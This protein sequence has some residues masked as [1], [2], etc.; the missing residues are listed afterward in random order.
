M[1]AVIQIKRSTGAGVPGSGSSALAQGELAYS[2][3]LSSGSEVGA[4]KLYIGMPADPATGATATAIVIGG[5][6]YTN[7]LSGTAGNAAASKAVILDANNAVSGLGAVGATTFTGTTVNGGNVRIA[8]N[9]VSSTD[10]DGALNLNPNGSGLI[11]IYG[12][13]ATNSW[14]LPR[15]RGTATYVLTTNADGTTSWAQPVSVL[16]FDNAAG[17]TSTVNLLNQKLSFNGGTGISTSVS[18]QE[19]TI[20]IDTGEGG[21][22]TT[23]G[24]QTL[25][26]KTMDGSLNTFLNIGNA[27]LSNSSATI[28]GLVVELGGSISL[29]STNVAEGTNLYF[30]DARARAAVSATTSGDGFGNLT[31]DSASGT[32]T[33]AKVTAANVRGTLAAAN[34]A[35]YGS[36]GYDS[37][38]GTFTFTA[39]TDANIRDRMSAATSG[40]GYGDLTYNAAGGTFTFAKVTDANIRERFAATN[41]A[42]FGSVAYDSASGTFTFTAVTA[43]NIRDQISA[44]TN[45]DATGFGNLEYNT[46]TGAITMTKVSVA[47]VRSTLGAATTGGGF[48][49]LTYDNASG[50]FT[51]ATVTAG[52]VRGTLST[53]NTGVGYGAV[54]Y[55]SSTGEISFAKV[56]DAEIRGT[57]SGG[58]GVSYNTTSGAISIGQSVATTDNVTFNKVT[59]GTSTFASTD[60]VSKA[61]VDSVAQG[62]D[63]KGSVVAATTASITL[64]GL[65]TIDGV[66]ITANMRVLVKN[67]SNATENGIWVASASAWTRADDMSTGDEFP[68][69]FTFVEQGTTYADTG[70]VQTAD[71]VTVGTTPITWVQF[72]SAGQF[73][74]GDGLQ[75]NGLVFSVNPNLAGNGL[76]YNAGVMSV[77]V[78]TAT[79]VISGDSIDIAAGG[80]T[81]AMLQNSGITF[82][83]TSGSTS[84]SLGSA[85]SIVGSGAV[86]TAGA[87][88]SITISVANATT[89]ST[90]LASFSATNFAVTDGAVSIKAGGVNLTTDVT[91]TL[92]AVNGGTGL[93]SYAVGDLVFANTTQTLS[94]LAATGTGF[95]L[96]SAGA[97]T[98]PTYGKIGLTTHVDG[99][100]A[101]ANGGTGRSTLAA[102]QLLVGDGTNA[103]AQSANLKFEAAANVGGY[104]NTANVLT[105][106]GA[107]IA[108]SG[109]DTVITANG[110][111]GNIVLVPNG[112]GFVDIGGPNSGSSSL[113]S[114][115]G[116][117]LNITGG[118][119]LNLTANTTLTLATTSSDIVM[120]LAAST[121]TKVSISG[122]TAAQYATGIEDNDL[123]NALW[124]KNYATLDGGTY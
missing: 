55:N 106:G 96:I 4:G 52:D 75:L 32:F 114:S 47:N 107:S 87:G 108:T 41:T 122:P 31:Y 76:A 85:L 80:V 101:V 115:N 45:V 48:G 53:T 60:A 29:T 56:T 17:S 58:T 113:G 44:G 25:T 21:L 26:N 28:N 30:T 22:V 78:N 62:L 54:S 51:F 6:F 120:S 94:T 20:A 83:G 34:T 42:G 89:T 69:A 91:G 100:L 109:N 92:P 33:F 110:T 93:S 9:T 12:G 112:T 35:G 81:N 74:A 61:Y 43:Q 3:A 24:T 82:T 66:S 105:V 121:A 118:A 68:G 16:T 38:S 46:T 50:T 116:E 23:T 19:V 111:N 117:N 11:Q 79:L 99:T 102:T 13:D 84:V 39:V 77:N 90:G 37:A 98:A 119:A 88:G 86:S 67:Q 40:T 2:A 36:L 103:V 64:S 5:S 97:G 49:S 95:A 27:S 65:Q 7:L 8:G 73:T 123:V 57:L 70:W 14:S 1:A 15:N 71:N 72:S 10:T 124:V 18:G 59:L 104:T 63:A